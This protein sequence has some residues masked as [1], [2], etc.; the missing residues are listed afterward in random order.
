MGEGVDVRKRL[1]V[2][3]IDDGDR[4]RVGRRDRGLEEDGEGVVEVEVEVERELFITT[5]RGGRGRG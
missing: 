3:S 1:S 4:G 5:R 2:S